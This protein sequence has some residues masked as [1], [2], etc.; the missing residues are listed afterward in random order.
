MIT[1]KEACEITN[2]VRNEVA[3]DYK[4]TLVV[5]LEDRWA[6]ILTVCGEAMLQPPTFFVF[7][8]DGRVEWF[9]IPPIENLDLLMQGEDIPFLE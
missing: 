6:F 1:Y 3:P 7:K 5:E 8:D 4:H 2:K 9:S